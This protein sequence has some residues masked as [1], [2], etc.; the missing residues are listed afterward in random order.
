MEFQKAKS[1]LSQHIDDN[2]T[3]IYSH[4]AAISRKIIEEKPENAYQ[5]FENL[6]LQIKQSKLNIT[7][8]DIPRIDI[9]EQEKQEIQANMESILVSC[10]RKPER[11]TNENK[12]DD[13][14][15]DNDDDNNNNDNDEQEEEQPI[16]LTKCANILEYQQ[17]LQ[18]AGIYIDYEETYLLQNAFIRLIRRFPEIENSRFWGKIQ[19]IN[20]DYWIVEAKL[21]EYPEIPEDKPPK[22]EDPGKGI[23]EFVYFVITNIEN[24]EWIKLNDATPEQIK[25]SR[26]VY[27]LFTGN[28]SESVGGQTHFEWT[29]SE[30]LRSQIARISSSTILAPTDYYQKPEEDDEE[31]PFIIE[32]NE[33]FV[34][35]ED[36]GINEDSWCHSRGHLRLEGRLKKYIKPQYDEEDE[37]NEIEKDQEEKEENEKEPSAE[38][39]EEEIPILQSISN[40]KCGEFN[41][42]TDEQENESS[43]CWFIRKINE[44]MPYKIVTINN[45]LWN[46]AKTIYLSNTKKFINI[47]IG[48]GIKYRNKYFTPSIPAL[49]QSQFNEFQ[50]IEITNPEN[51]NE[52]E[53]MT[54]KQSVFSV[55]SEQMPPTPSNNEENKDENNEENQEETID[56]KVEEDAE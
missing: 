33:E 10:G 26:Q 15:D 36:G 6:S 16:D 30:L 46:G 19:A 51:E 27:R 2:G 25:K 21:S 9:N 53:T 12:V 5:L 17:L 31:N 47:Y 4:I 20:N 23:N 1:F 50:E 44:N 56:D 37:N 49:I 8:Y 35:N 11:K 38:E 54:K 39:L 41:N 52:E 18:Y 28:L 29:E 3:S 32:L 55:Q 48:N 24:G 22:I 43:N 14:D 13:A 45:K 42:G 40:D 34:P 7:N